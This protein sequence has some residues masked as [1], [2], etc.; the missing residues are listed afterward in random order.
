MGWVAM[1]AGGRV[2]DDGDNVCGASYF[3]GAGFGRVSGCGLSVCG[4]CSSH[5]PDH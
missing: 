1:V 2:D 4:C 5:K 3:H